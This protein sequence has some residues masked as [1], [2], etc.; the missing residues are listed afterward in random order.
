MKL[1]ERLALAGWREEVLAIVVVFVCNCGHFRITLLTVFKILSQLS[2]SWLLQVMVGTTEEFQGQERMVI[3]LS[4]VN[5]AM[6]ARTRSLV[7]IKM[8]NKTKLG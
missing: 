6:I 1:R 5:H 2:D 8:Y 7:G 4:T 3:L